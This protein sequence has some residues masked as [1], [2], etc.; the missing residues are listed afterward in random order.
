MCLVIIL[1]QFFA[2]VL[3]FFTQPGKEQALQP[4]LDCPVLQATALGLGLSKTLPA[5]LTPEAG[6]GQALHLHNHELLYTNLLSDQQALGRPG[7][8]KAVGGRQ[9]CGR[10]ELRGCAVSVMGARGQCTLQARP[11]EGHRK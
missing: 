8:L 7:C 3:R 2:A 4:G 11:E 6:P 1:S 9:S 10:E 5:W